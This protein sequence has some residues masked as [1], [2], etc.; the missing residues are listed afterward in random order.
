MAHTPNL[1]EISPS[2]FQLRIAGEH[3]H[4]LNS[5]ILVEDSG[6]SLIDTGW[7]DSAT[8]I[9]SA[10]NALGRTRNDVTRIILTH[11]HEDH[12]GS[13][14]AITEW[15]DIQVIAG[16]PEASAIRGNEPGPLAQLTPAE[17][18]IH[19][20]PTVPPAGP[21]CRVDLTVVDGSVIN[22]AGGAH[23]LLTPGHTQ[24]SI[25]L[26]LPAL[27]TVLTGDTVAE[28]GGEVILGVFN[29]N[30][31]ETR[32]SANRIAATGASIAGFGHG[33]AVLHAASARIAAATDPFA[34]EPATAVILG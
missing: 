28:F 6:V 26:H 10:V 24:G 2:L 4:A 9:E 32:R 33:E 31:A 15:G 14:A 17:I 3:A 19:A 5:F 22:I 13:A 34:E 21:A 7:P 12:A 1:L 23:V 27:D 11:F 25:A 16:A 30:R 18:T 29:V 20:Q 8:L